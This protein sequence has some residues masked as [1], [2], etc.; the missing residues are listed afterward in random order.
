MAPLQAGVKIFRDPGLGNDGTSAVWLSAGSEVV[1][2]RRATDAGYRPGAVVP[3]SAWSEPSASERALLLCNERE[4]VRQG[5]T[6]IVARMPETV[7]EPLRAL[8][9]PHLES[10]ERDELCA[11]AVEQLAPFFASRTDLTV[12][13][14]QV[15]AGGLRTATAH[16]FPEGPALI[17]LHVDRWHD[18]AY[19]CRAHAQLTINLAPRDR[20]L[21]FLNVPVE[22]LAQEFDDHAADPAG[23]PRYTWRP[24]PPQLNQRCPS[25]P[26]VRVRIRPGE[27]YIA[28]TEN[29]VHDVSLEGSPLDDVS[30]TVRGRCRWPQ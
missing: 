18:G 10:P 24:F 1:S 12:P 15:Q 30:F 9:A 4:E 19:G 16:P 23:A 14:L 8:E 5:R 20:F 3:I 13:G 25:Y 26:L 11:R 21:V 27:A 17:G 6:V 28:P 7:M 22:Q 2:G 29:L